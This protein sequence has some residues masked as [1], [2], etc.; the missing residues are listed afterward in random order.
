LGHA[1]EIDTNLLFRKRGEYPS[2]Y[3]LSVNGWCARPLGAE[4][5]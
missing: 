4:L 3:P 2:R 1:G 5:E